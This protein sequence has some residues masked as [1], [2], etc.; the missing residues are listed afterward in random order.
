VGAEGDLEMK[1]EGVV[2]GSLRA[3]ER[4]FGWKA[5]KW[6][7]MPARWDVCS[8]AG[9]GSVLREAVVLWTGN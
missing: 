1:D 9:T 2:D 7:S 6:N 3:K 5:M 4:G 8:P